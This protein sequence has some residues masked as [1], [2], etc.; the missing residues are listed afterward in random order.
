VTASLIQS[1]LWGDTR[2]L[3]Q[4]QPSTRRDADS[5]QWAVE[6]PANGKAEVTAVF[7]TKY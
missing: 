7:D 2:I 3:S 4:S 1:G 5:A 6:I